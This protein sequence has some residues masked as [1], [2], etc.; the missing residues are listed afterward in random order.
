MSSIEPELVAHI[1][2][3]P[4]EDGPRL[5]YADWL[6]DRGDPRGEFIVVQCALAVADRD[7]RP[8]H[9][10]NPL[11]DRSSE[12]EASSGDQWREPALEIALGRYTFRRGLIEVIDVLQPDI[13][14]AHLREVCPLLRAIKTSQVTVNDVFRNIDALPLDELTIYKITD[15]LIIHRV[16]EDPRFERLRRL[17]IHFQNGRPHLKELARLRIPLRRF[18]LRFDR[19]QPFDEPALLSHLTAH[20]A[21]GALRSLDLAHARTEELGILE[22]L[23]DLEELTLTSCSFAV[24]ELLPLVLPRL[25]LLAITDSVMDALDPALLIAVFP[26]LRRLRLS[27]ARLGD[28]AALSIAASPHAARLRRLDLSNNHISPVGARALADSEHLRGLVSL[29]LTGNANAVSAL[30]HVRQSLVDA[31]VRL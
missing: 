9:E 31:E 7:D 17:D 21:R 29:D 24:Q 23:P 18:A 28:R 15:A 10:T 11:R 4:D 19:A 20:P 3:A 13:D 22:Q 2:A 14:G 25:T 27:N 16:F 8:A 6:S 26:S 5:V 30:D 1:V 12:L